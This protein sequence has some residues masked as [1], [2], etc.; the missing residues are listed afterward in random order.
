MSQLRI[1]SALNVIKINN[2]K[3]LVDHT[4][5]NDTKNITTLQG[6]KA[7]ENIMKLNIYN[8][9]M[10]EIEETNYDSD[11]IELYKSFD[12]KDI[13]NNDKNINQF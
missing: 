5:F 4:I 10:E 7:L 11:I 2:L 6:S 12:M 3:L 1:N 9:Q 13:M 8:K